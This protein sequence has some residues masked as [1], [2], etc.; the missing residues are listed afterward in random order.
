MLKRFIAVILS[1][2]IGVSLASE[3]SLRDYNQYQIPK[4]YFIPVMSMQEFS[5]AYTE[6][7]EP[8]N[9][10]TTNDIYMFDKKIYSRFSNKDIFISNKLYF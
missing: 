4:G 8:L 10:I 9:F 1:L 3:P 2:C 6:E 7:G 5:T